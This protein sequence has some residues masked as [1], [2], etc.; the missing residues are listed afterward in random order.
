MRLK[1]LVLVLMCWFNSFCQDTL[2]PVPDT[3]KYQKHL[4]KI[5]I[6]TVLDFFT[7]FAGV[8]VLNGN[9]DDEK[10]N[11]HFYYNFTV[12]NIIKSGSVRITNYFFTEFGVKMYFDSIS[13]ISEDSYKFKN[14]L[15]YCIN[16]SKLAINVSFCTKSQF[17][18]HFDFRPDT[19]DGFE[20]FLYTTYLSPGYI[21]YSGGIKIFF[22]DFFTVEFGL[23]NGHK[24]KIRNQEIFDSRMA[25]S[26]YGLKKG[27]KQ[28]TDYGFN[29]AINLT[30]KEIFKNVF[31][32]NFSQFN[33]SRENAKMIKYY[34]CDI[35]NAFHYRFLKYL[36]L[37]L[38]TQMQYDYNISLK[39]K[40]TNTMTFGFYLNN[41]L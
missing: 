26:L 20:R 10:S 39:P 29:M 2:Q 6:V 36:R 15:S 40:F 34:L 19:M 16:H 22:N 35:N 24:I 7:T 31:W 23:V 8:H 38:R 18:R 5:E 1:L 17:F 14:A 33:V 9:T 28:K 21:D 25:R 4:R 41:K 13:V 11:V 32:E 30:P 37:T 3:A 12:N 27:E